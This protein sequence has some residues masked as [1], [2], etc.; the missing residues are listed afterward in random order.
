MLTVIFYEERKSIR[1]S[2]AAKSA[3]TQKR[4]RERNE[5]QRRKIKVVKH[6]IWRP[7]QEEL[8]EEA[9][10]TEELNT[11]SLGMHKIK[12][13]ST[14]FNYN[15]ILYLSIFPFSDKEQKI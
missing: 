5:D 3:A 4:L 8:L 14:I 15:D 10:Q 6:D 1:R 13:I 7:T 11:K 12:Y 2:T 9:L